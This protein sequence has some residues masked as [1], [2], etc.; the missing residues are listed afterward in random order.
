MFF[1]TAYALTG[2]DSGHH[3]PMMP[4]PGAPIVLGG[5]ANA[6]T[7]PASVRRPGPTCAGARRVVSTSSF[8]GRGRAERS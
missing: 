3:A 5:V 2:A 6:V 8:G 7:P 1:R 4:I